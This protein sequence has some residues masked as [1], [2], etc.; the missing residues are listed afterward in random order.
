M[1]VQPVTPDSNG[2]RPPVGISTLNLC[3]SFATPLG[4]EVSCL[5]M[6]D[7]IGCK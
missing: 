6:I 2:A 7:A 4:D 1:H 3:K 5:Q